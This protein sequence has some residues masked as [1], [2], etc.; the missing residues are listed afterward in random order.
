ME[1]FFKKYDRLYIAC[2]NLMVNVDQQ[3]HLQR[4][5]QTKMGHTMYV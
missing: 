1:L 2:G 5:T 3:W 4:Q